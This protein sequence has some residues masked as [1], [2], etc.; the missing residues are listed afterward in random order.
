MKKKAI[1]IIVSVVLVCALGLV[2]SLVLDWPVSTDS[3][4][5]NIGKSSRFSRKA[6]TERIDNMEE[7]LQ[8]DE[9]YK[10]SIVLAYSV[11]QTRA[12][13]FAAL[14]DLSNQVADGIPEFEG[15]LKDMNEAAPMVKNVVVS[16]SEAGLDLNAVLKGESCP[17][18]TQNTI[19]ASLAY[20]T[21]QKQNDLATRFI[22]TTDK[23]NKKAEA[24]D[25]LLFVRDQWMDYQRMTAALEGDAKAAKGLEKKGT[26]LPSEKVVSAL[27]QFDVVYEIALLTG[28]D[29]AYRLDVDNLLVRAIPAGTMDK[30]A[31]AIISGAEG[32]ETVIQGMDIRTQLSLLP[33]IVWQTFRMAV[34]EE[35]PEVMVEGRLAGKYE[36]RYLY[37]AETLEGAQLCLGANKD[38]V[39]VRQLVLTDV[40]PGLGHEV[41][42][43]LGDLIVQTSLGYKRALARL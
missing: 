41:V 25:E 30:L 1:I 16:L 42:P 20:T 26:L 21:L 40:V 35:L 33:E 37:Q 22:D 34:T 36:P 23:Y 28:A 7:L 14:V 6:A 29:L 9:D 10:N 15:V 2:L 39:V 31:P 19:N 8:A 13:Q 43:G 17:D 32:A 5:G 3:T 24:S 4:S 18:V 38:I 12:M 11:M 27:N